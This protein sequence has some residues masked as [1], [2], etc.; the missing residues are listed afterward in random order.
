MALWLLNCLMEISKR[1]SGCSPASDPSFIN[2]CA[3]NKPGYRTHFIKCYKA[4]VRSAIINLFKQ[5]SYLGHESVDDLIQD[6][7]LSMFENNGERLRSFKGR[8]NCSLKTWIRVVASRKALNYLRRLYLQDKMHDNL[9]FG[10][11]Q[12]R[13]PHAEKILLQQEQISFIKDEISRLSDL[14]RLVFQMLYEDGFSYNKVADACQITKGA[15]YTRVSRIKD[16]LRKK[17]ASVGLLQ[18]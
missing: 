14:D 3:D 4:T 6:V 9:K 17:A 2:R 18:N 1:N 5:Q 12:G 11:S 16:R 10:E 15:L 13:I 7:F 8:N